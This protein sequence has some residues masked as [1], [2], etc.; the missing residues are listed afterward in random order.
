MARLEVT[1]TFQ[2]ITFPGHLH[3]QESLR[4]GTNFKFQDSD[5]LIVTYPKSGTTWM[6]EVVTLVSC[7][8]NPVKAQTQPNWA[9]APWLEQYYCPDVLKATQGP[10]VLTTHLPYKLLAPA[11]QGS[12]AKVIYVARN[13]KDVVVSYYYFHKMAKFLNDPGTFSEFL[14]AFLEGT[15]YYGSWFDHVKG[16]T[17]NALNIDNFLYITYEEMWEDLCGSM[18]KVSRFLQ[19]PLLEDELNSAQKSCTFDSMRENCMV[20]YTLIP[21][22]IMDHSKG[23]F[24]R[25]GQIGDWI[26]TFSQEQSRNFDVVYASKMEDSMLKFV[27]ETNKV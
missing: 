13:P 25:K 26:N 21:Q 19:C 23:K 20:N 12:K 14:S 6:Q 2:G 10:R 27:W 16:W 15:V 17:S 9:R 4:Y 24:M 7:R 11:L 5:I 8:G 18:E 22:E 3:T 1:E